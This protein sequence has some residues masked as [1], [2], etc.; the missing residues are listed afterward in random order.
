M[1]TSTSSI[2]SLADQC[3]WDQ[4]CYA[5]VLPAVV[6]LPPPVASVATPD[7]EMEALL[8]HLA[9]IARQYT[10][11]DI[12]LEKCR[13]R[14]ARAYGTTCVMLLGGWEKL[15]DYRLVV[16]LLPAGLV[17]VTVGKHGWADTPRYV[18]ERSDAL[19]SDEEQPPLFDLPAPAIR[20]GAYLKHHGRAQEQEIAQRLLKVSPRIPVD[21]PRIQAALQQ[22]QADVLQLQADAL[23]TLMWEV[24]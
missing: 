8:G 24:Y 13:R 16:P 22:L 2:W 14:M 18:E 1:P 9:L 12:S 15:R 7:G 21:G 4:L 19:R 17:T 10:T 23:H 11:D 3:K 5:S 20:P 6:L